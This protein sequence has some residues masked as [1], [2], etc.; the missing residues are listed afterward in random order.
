M[1]KH[2]VAHPNSVAS[3]GRDRDRILG[4]F[5][6]RMCRRRHM[7]VLLGVTWRKNTRSAS[8]REND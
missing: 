5:L 7:L 1:T 8:L 4:P 2:N 6:F 3:P